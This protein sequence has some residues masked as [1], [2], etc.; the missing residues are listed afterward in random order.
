MIYVSFFFGQKWIHLFFQHHIWNTYAHAH[1]D[2]VN[3]IDMLER[4]YSL[5][6]VS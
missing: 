6:G 4:L 2:I 1:L 3:N 5:C